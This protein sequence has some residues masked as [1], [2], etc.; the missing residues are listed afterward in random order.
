MYLPLKV[1]N[2]FQE[3]NSI[4]KLMPSRSPLEN[5]PRLSEKLAETSARDVNS[6]SSS[7]FTNMQEKGVNIYKYK[8]VSCGS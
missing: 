8:K 2:V 4:K 5:N 1:L 3:K 6:K 7:H